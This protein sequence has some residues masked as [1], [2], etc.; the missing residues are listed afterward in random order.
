MLIGVAGN[1]LKQNAIAPPPK[2]AS[3]ATE[4]E[5]GRAGRNFIRGALLGVGA[6]MAGVLLFGAPEYLAGVVKLPPQLTEPGL[7]VRGVVCAARLGTGLRPG[8]RGARVDAACYAALLFSH[9]G[10]AEDR[11]RLHMQLDHDLLL[12]LSE[13]AAAVGVLVLS[14]CRR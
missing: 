10:V 9:A 14:S 11:G 3:M 4:E 12:L 7:L 8:L 6:T 13:R 1:V 2:D 5:A